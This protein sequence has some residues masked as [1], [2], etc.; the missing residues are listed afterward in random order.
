M[1]TEGGRMR[2]IRLGWWVGW[3]DLKGKIILFL[4][5]LILKNKKCPS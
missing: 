2:L 4:N 1:K 5:K 3:G